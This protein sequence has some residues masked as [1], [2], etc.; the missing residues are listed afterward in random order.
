MMSKHYYFTT[1][2]AHWHRALLVLGGAAISACSSQGEQDTSNVESVSQGLLNT[3]SEL[4]TY[5]PTVAPCSGTNVTNCYNTALPPRPS[6]IRSLVAARPRRSGD[7]PN[8]ASTYYSSDSLVTAGGPVTQPVTQ[9]GPQLSDTRA[10]T[11]SSELFEVPTAASASTGGYNEGGAMQILPWGRSSIDGRLVLGPIGSNWNALSFAAFSPENLGYDLQSQV[12][13]H[14]RPVSRQRQIGYALLSDPR[15]PNGACTTSATTSCVY[16]ANA[17]QWH[18]PDQVYWDLC[19]TAASEAAPRTGPNLDTGRARSCTSQNSASASDRTDGDCYDVSIVAAVGYAWSDLA[20]L[21]STDLTVFVS[22]AKVAPSAASGG[23]TGAQA[24]NNTDQTRIYPRT[25]ASA[26]PDYHLYDAPWPASEFVAQARTLCVE[27]GGPAW[28]QFL[29][30]QRH[31]HPQQMTVRGF[32]SNTTLSS[33]A[34]PWGSILGPQLIEPTTTADGRVALFNGGQFGLLYAVN[35]SADASTACHVDAWGDLRP[36]SRAA[37]DVRVSQ[38]YGFARHPIRDTQGTLVTPGHPVG[39]SYPWIDRKGD[40]IFFSAEGNRDAYKDLSGD[41]V[42]DNKNGKGNVVVGAWT[43][44]KMVIPDGALNFTDW[45][46]DMRAPEYAFKHAMRLYQGDAI[47][48]RPRGTIHMFSFESQFNHLDALSPTLPQDVVWKVSSDTERNMD[49]SFDDYLSKD[50]LVVAHM[51][52][53]LRRPSMVLQANAEAA[54]GGLPNDNRYNAFD[55][56]F[57]PVLATGRML[58]NNN[59]PEN[60]S[61]RPQYRFTQTPKLQ[62]AS[63]ISVGD[64]GMNIAPAM[65]RLL[66]GARVEPVALGGVIGKGVYL[67][68]INDHIEAAFANPNR[69]NWYFG[70]WLDARDLA[71][72]RTVYMFEPEVSTSGHKAA[73]WIAVSANEVVVQGPMSRQS[74]WIAPRVTPSSYFHLGIKSTLAGTGAL[75]TRSVQILIDGNPVGIP[76]NFSPAAA[77][78]PAT[79]TFGPGMDMSKGRFYVGRPV[80]LPTMFSPPPPPFQGWIDELR[81]LAIPAYQNEATFQELACNSALGSLARVYAADFSAPLGTLERTLANRATLFGIPAN[82][83]VCEQ[84]KLESHSYPNDVGLQDTRTLCAARVHK[85]HD[86]NRC[87]RAVKFGAQVLTSSSVTQSL[88]SFA[89]VGFC[90]GCHQSSSDPVPGL[91]SAALLPGVTPLYLD[92]RRRPT[93]HARILGAYVPAEPGGSNVNS[94]G[95]W[96]PLAPFD[97][98][99]PVAPVDGTYMDFLFVGRSKQTPQ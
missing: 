35:T 25:S 82:G 94:A 23:L 22:R 13:P 68:G 57:T 7:A 15:I 37:T 20:E 40:N 27:N 93:D 92:R 49:L 81:V 26:L 46:N 87:L 61:N 28:C 12:D 3:T 14:K 45:G 6:L 67:D 63:T 9:T 58:T 96:I 11:F 59:Q 56:G 10:I 54:A 36:I 52:A 76:M 91:R 97:T 55:D 21:V 83:Q 24:W 60:V 89:G 71:T 85:N 98:T 95:S 74:T 44:G 16:P 78:F 70:M 50:A 77:P 66:G 47:E 29:T 48:V 39:A 17:T 19:T 1:Q 90:V 84:L 2:R 80:T 86:A 99:P 53:P 65:L 33:P 64:G 41:S 18:A 38:T 69:T 43:R 62:N 34:V 73:S 88:S 51:N 30:K 31:I 32:T 75:T 4:M 8:T 5:A 72:L 79:G 42:F